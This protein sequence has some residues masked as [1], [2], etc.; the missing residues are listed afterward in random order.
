MTTAPYPQV[1]NELLSA[2][3]DE[4]VTEEE[5]RLV[6]Q[7]V[8]EDADVAWRLRSLQATV[9]LLRELPALSLPRAFV[10]TPEQVG[11]AAGMAAGT[12]PMEKAAVPAAGAG[13]AQ[14]QTPRRPPAE[15]DRGF[16]P[17]LRRSWGRFW[18]GGSPALRNAMAASFAV[19]LIL[20]VA[21]GFVANLSFTSPGSVATTAS[22]PQAEGVAQAPLA[23]QATAAV[24]REPAQ[25]DAAAAK[26]AAAPAAAAQPVDPQPTAA[27]QAAA[28]QPLQSQPAASAAAPL[29]AAGAQPAG[30]IVSGAGAPGALGGAPPGLARGAASGQSAIDA[31]RATAGDMPP[32]AAAAPRAYDA[33]EAEPTGAVTGT[34]SELTA[35]AAVTEP[36]TRELEAAAALPRLKPRPLPPPNRPQ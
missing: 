4:A 27:K 28:E 33:T 23:A 24:G 1:T 5:R 3:I 2:Y 15:E 9:H 8:A 35:A 16:W 20:L 12:P 19:L 29:P 30:A 18:Q 26:Q 34:T 10:L 31:A 25:Q 36:T 14:V 21:P 7:A 13:A 22:Q 32:A 11:Q 6:E 17:D